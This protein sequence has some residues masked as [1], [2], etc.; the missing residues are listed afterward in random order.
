[1]E[2]EGE[3]RRSLGRLGLGVIGLQQTEDY[4]HANFPGGGGH[5]KQ[6]GL[7]GRQEGVGGEPA[8]QDAG[9]KG[10]G[11]HGEEDKVKGVGGLIHGIDHLRYKI[12]SSLGEG[13]NRRLGI[14]N[15]R[16]IFT[17]QELT[18]TWHLAVA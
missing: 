17:I 8:G 4:P 11:G 16:A 9:E 1:M 5:L 12:F 13:H 2:K 15:F 18:W 14:M 6:L 10:E 7:V 3:V